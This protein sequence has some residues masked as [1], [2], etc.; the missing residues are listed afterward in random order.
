[1]KRALITT[2]QASLEGEIQALT[3]QLM[4]LHGKTKT[5]AEVTWSRSEQQ[6]EGKSVVPLLQKTDTH[7]SDDSGS[8]SDNYASNSSS[9]YQDT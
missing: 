2:R 5:P 1:M 6:T 9:S 3:K 8:S 7:D 4:S